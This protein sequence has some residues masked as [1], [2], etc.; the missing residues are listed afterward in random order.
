[1]TDQFKVLSIKFLLTSDYIMLSLLYKRESILLLRHWIP[2]FAGMTYRTGQ[3][4]YLE[5]LVYGNSIS[6]TSSASRDI[7]A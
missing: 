2:A 4:E 3:F 5:M 7:S 6:A 1:M